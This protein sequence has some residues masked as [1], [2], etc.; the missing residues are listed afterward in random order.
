M[1]VILSTIFLLLGA[2]VLLI[3][4]LGMH[5]F[6]DALSRQHAATMAATLGVILSSLGTMIYLADWSI[7][8]RLFLMIVF[9]LATVP[10]ASHALARAAVVSK[11]LVHKRHHEEV[12]QADKQD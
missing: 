12:W 3:S 8:I 11:M 5:I 6:L 4:A 9:M 10:L 2:I 7:A 1:I